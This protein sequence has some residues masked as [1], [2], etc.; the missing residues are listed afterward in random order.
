MHKL[1]G[2]NLIAGQILNADHEETAKAN[3]W[4]EDADAARAGQS[5]PR[6]VEARLD[7]LEG[8]MAEEKQRRQS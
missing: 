4:L 8:W 7:A 1:Q 2:G 6:T 5:G 3:G